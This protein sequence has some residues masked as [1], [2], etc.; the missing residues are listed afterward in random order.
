MLEERDIYELRREGDRAVYMDHEEKRSI[1]IPDEYCAGMFQ[2]R[3]P[4]HLTDENRYFEAITHPLEGP[5]LRDIA[6]SKHAS[7]A[8]IIISDATRN[9]PTAKVSEYL[10]D[11][12]VAGGVPEENITFF[13]ALGV[14]RDAT[15]EEMRDFIGDT[16]YNRG[17]HIENHDPYTEEKLVYLGRTSFGTPVK[18]NKKAQQCDV[19]VTVGKTEL[20]E[21]AGFSGGRKSILPGVAAEETILIN[22]RPEM[23]FA[24][25]TGAGNLDHNPIHLDMLETAKMFGVDFSVNFVVDQTGAPSE[26]FVGGL[27]GSHM[28][29]VEYLRQFCNITVPKKIDL[30]VVTPGSPLNCDMYQGVK[31]IFAL[32]HLLTPDSVVLFY[33]AF[34]EGMNSFD[35]VDPLR[36]FHTDYDA[37]RKYTWDH[38]KIQMDHTLP[39]LDI[40][41]MGVKI[42]VCSDTVDKQDLLDLQMLP[43][44]NMDEALEDAI[45]LT[46]K[47]NPSVGFFPSS[48]SAVIRYGD[49]VE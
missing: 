17:L 12:L 11:E 47:D 32:Q 19:K 5:T 27:E 35:Y 33:G 3:K 16:L 20:H 41:Q 29:A 15:Q 34:P 2:A 37:A 48:Q 26:V 30:F 23:I 7:T 24:D 28:A 10:V 9:V 43:Y 4:P 8:A 25:G 21:M 39:T 42:V 46:G 6:M 40:L 14:H 13:V 38:Y 31:A 44:E 22:H 1:C 18:V 45:K 36:K 49:G